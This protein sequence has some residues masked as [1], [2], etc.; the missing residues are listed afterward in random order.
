MSTNLER[1]TSSPAYQE[2][3]AKRNK[4]IW[5]LAVLTFGSYFAFILAIAFS[6]ASLGKPLGG[7]PVSIGILLGLA[8]ILFNFLITFLYVRA[9]NRDL[10]P[11][12]ARVQAQKGE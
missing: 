7:G 4:I 6:P 9:A 1:F 11:L 8:L 10:E 5:P 3:I 12:I 2:L